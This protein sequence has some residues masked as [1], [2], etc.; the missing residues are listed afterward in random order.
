MRNKMATKALDSFGR[1]KK[2]P[3]KHKIISWAEGADEKPLLSLQNQC[4]EVHWCL[5]TSGGKPI[6]ANP[7]SGSQGFC[8]VYRGSKSLLLSA[9]SATEWDAE[10]ENL[11][12]VSWCVVSILHVKCPKESAL[13]DVAFVQ[14]GQ[15]PYVLRNTQHTSNKRLQ[16]SHLYMVHATH[17]EG[18]ISN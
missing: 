1:G 10:E 14:Y 13:T 16:P 3:K 2:I 7:S 17:E 18:K 8:L 11:P 9:L 15:I 5:P 4:Q 12:G 6:T